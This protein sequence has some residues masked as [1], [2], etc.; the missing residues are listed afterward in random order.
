MI[1]LRKPPLHYTQYCMALD[2]MD[3]YWIFWICLICRSFLYSII[4]CYKRSVDRFRG[5]VLLVYFPKLSNCKAQNS[6][7]VDI[8]DRAVTSVG[9]HLPHHGNRIR[10]S[11]FRSAL[12]L[13]RGISKWSPQLLPRGGRCTDLMRSRARSGRTTVGPAPT[14]DAYGTTPP[15]QLPTSPT[16]LT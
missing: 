12:S 13:H 15:Y 3:W 7:L 16:N 4:V 10:N 6:L 1:A 14:H 8:Y 9:R 11:P 2:F 5:I